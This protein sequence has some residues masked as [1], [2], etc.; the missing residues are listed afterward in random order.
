MALEIAP[1]NLVHP[2]KPSDLM[3]LSPPDGI[4]ETIFSCGLPKHPSESVFREEVV[5]GS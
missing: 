1:S 4:H 2:E 3:L 5:N